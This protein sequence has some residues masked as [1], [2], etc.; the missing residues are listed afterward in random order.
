MRPTVGA[1]EVQPPLAFGHARIGTTQIVRVEF[2]WPTRSE[3]KE[4]REVN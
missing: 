3:V 1:D 2:V 4:E